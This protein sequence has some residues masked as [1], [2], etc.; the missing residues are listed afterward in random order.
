MGIFPS[1]EQRF[2]SDKRI[3]ELLLADQPFLDAYVGQI[4]RLIGVVDVDST[5]PALLRSPFC[6]PE[7]WP[8]QQGICYYF[9]GYLPPGNATQG[10]RGKQEDKLLFS[11]GYG[12]DFVV[13]GGGGSGGSSREAAVPTVVAEPE[14]ERGGLGWLIRN[15]PVSDTGFKSV[16]STGSAQSISMPQCRICLDRNS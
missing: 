14:G 2:F 6:D 10:G 3:P 9:R 8:Q 5:N 7:I 13:R 4:V 16:P 15:G 1:S 12:V 11:C